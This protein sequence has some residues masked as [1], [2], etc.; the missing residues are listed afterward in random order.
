[1]R[2]LM[3]AAIVLIC[4]SLGAPAPAVGPQFEVASVRPSAKDMSDDPAVA[5]LFQEMGEGMRRVGEIPMTASDRVRM[6]HW[7]LLDLIAAAYRV[8]GVQ[9]SGPAWLSEEFF[10]IEAKVPEG[11][12]KED[13]HAMLQSLLEERFDL[14]VHRRTQTERGYAITV[15]K[16]GPRLI[17][18][19]TPQDPSHPPSEQEQTAKAMQGLEDMQ[20][21]M[22]SDVD[23]E[24]PGAGFTRLSWPSITMEELA[25]RLRPFTGV[26][27]VDGTGLTGSYA[28]TIE[29]AKDPDASGRT[30]FDALRRL[31]LKLEPREVMVDGVV[32][33]QVSKAPTPN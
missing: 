23:R 21:E 12:A 26:P 30:V 9:V 8:R 33:E 22:K 28:V 17:P 18:A 31:G 24:E 25:Y 4:V 13:L 27:V 20:K 14:R 19:E 15:G 11:T 5:K 6:Q 2:S 3:C 16:G 10:D 29:V 1:M 7:S 32:V